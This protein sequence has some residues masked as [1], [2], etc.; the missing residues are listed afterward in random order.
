MTQCIKVPEPHFSLSL[1][2]APLPK[3]MRQFLVY[4]V[5]IK[6]QKVLLCPS[7][8][9]FR[10]PYCLPILLSKASL[11]I[12]YPNLWSE[13]KEKHKFDLLRSTFL[14]RHHGM[15]RKKRQV[16][17]DTELVEVWKLK[18]F[19]ILQS[20]GWPNGFSLFRAQ[21]LS[22][23]KAEDTLILSSSLELYNFNIF[24]KNQFC[25]NMIYI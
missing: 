9:T 12:L 2:Q 23:E 20:T 11:V 10:T 25:W 15:S 6:T 19:L 7:P 5:Y 13:R 17:K 4:F 14:A 1:Q 24:L 16:W 22:S 21:F 18:S 3:N 8:R